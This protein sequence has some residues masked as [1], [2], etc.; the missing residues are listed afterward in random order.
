MASLPASSSTSMVY[1]G[2]RRN[3]EN[4][5]LLCGGEIKDGCCSG[6]PLYATVFQFLPGRVRLSAASENAFIFRS[7]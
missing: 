7:G 3:G 4:I 5:E 1:V 6:G 2:E